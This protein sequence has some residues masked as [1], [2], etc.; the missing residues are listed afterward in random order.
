ML[1]FARRRVLL[2]VVGACLVAGGGVAVAASQSGMDPPFLPLPD[3]FPLEN[4]VTGPLDGEPAVD[5][6]DVKGLRGFQGPFYN[7]A[8][9]TGTVEVLDATVRVAPGVT[10]HALGLA[11]NQTAGELRRVT[12]S[13]ELLSDSGQRLA[14]VSSV[15]P[16]ASARKGEPVPFVLSS[17]VPA[18]LVASVKYHAEGAVGDI[19]DR[20]FEI[21]PYWSKA[22]GDRG[23]LTGYPFADTA[24]SGPYPF[25]AFG[26]VVNLGDTDKT[27][28]IVGAWLDQDNRVLATG[29]LQR[30]TS[31]NP[32]DADPSVV[33]DTGTL[34]ARL[35]SDYVYTND[36]PA[37]AP[38]LGDARFVAWVGSVNP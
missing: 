3:G 20:N 32:D 12:V 24:T 23:R 36:D 26:S 7:P 5:L 33:A 15:S 10:W 19:L 28:S 17:T 18:N 1:R 16:V 8:V 35:M 38:S 22:Y 14:T 13:A 31:P 9:Q 21:Q 6:D 30:I 25:V 34:S 29:V 2:S 4:A 37:V 27:P 11:R